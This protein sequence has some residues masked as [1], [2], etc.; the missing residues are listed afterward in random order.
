M[1]EPGNKSVSQ[2]H[3]LFVDDLKQCQESYKVFKDV[4][5]IIVQVS[6]GTGSCY[7][8]SKYAEIVFKH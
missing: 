5:E 2:R 8:V 3:S 7:G 6:N 1:G 4:I